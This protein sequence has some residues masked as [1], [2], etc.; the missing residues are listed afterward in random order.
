MATYDYPLPDGSTWR[1]RISLGRRVLT[2]ADEY[3]GAQYGF[4]RYNGYSRI[5]WKLVP[6]EDALSPLEIRRGKDYA[7]SEFRTG[8][9]TITLANGTGGYSLEP[10]YAWAG[11]YVKV[12]ALI[13]PT[14][15]P[16][17]A[18]LFRLFTG[19]IDEA[20]DTFAGGME[21]RILSCVDALADLAQLEET[22]EASQG[23][24]E[25]TSDRMRRLVNS[26]SN[27]VGRVRTYGTFVDPAMQPTT[28]AG[29]RV[30]EIRRTAATEGGEVWADSA[31]DSSVDA[32][33]VVFAGREWPSATKSAAAQA[34]FGGAGI[35]IEE[36]RPAVEM[37]RVVNVATISN[38]GG[39]A[40]T[41][42]D[43]DT[44]RLQRFGRRTFR[45]LDLLAETGIGGDANSANLASRIVT[46]LRSPKQAV[47][48]VTMPVQSWEA[49][50]AIADLDFLYRV[51]ITIE[52]LGEGS[53]PRSTAFESHVVGVHHR[54][55]EGVDWVVTW[56]L[57][58]TFV[59]TLE[60]E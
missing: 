18:R 25:S 56:T 9:A 13:I 12:E 26:S 55:T 11:D 51:F 47:R 21:R 41:A 29:N 49:L 60:E 42:T 50:E 14:S 15:G 39:T 6:G 30:Q 20:Y 58:D 5:D 17:D 44:G 37:R 36:A 24:G 57:D 3:G 8:R 1:I 32:P 38:A 7:L 33:W 54:I 48:R 16:I 4:S 19:R 23:A 52:A 40:Q 2:S 31:E 28:L 53:S 43:T 27:V 59:E 46:A 45:R 34:V 10:N 35:P 22:P